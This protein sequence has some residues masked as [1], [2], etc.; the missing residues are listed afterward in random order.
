[1]KQMKK[2]LLVAAAVA[3]SVIAIAPLNSYAQSMDTNASVSVGLSSN[4]T[5]AASA[6]IVTYAASHPWL[7]TILT[8]MGILRL[9]LKPLIGIIEV[10]VQNTASKNDDA[11]L[12]K[13]ESATWFKWVL[14]VLDWLGSIKAPGSNTNPLVK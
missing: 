5:D 4:V 2:L 13:V 1:M 8:L 6:T 3:V 9:C 10:V 11:A 12:A 14:W 7:V